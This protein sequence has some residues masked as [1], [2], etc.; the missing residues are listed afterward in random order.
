MRWLP[1]NRMIADGLTKDRQEPADLL[2]SCVRAGIYQIS[3]EESVLARQAA[4]R[5]ER[6]RLNQIKTVEV[7]REFR[8]SRTM[9]PRTVSHSFWVIHGNM[10]LD[11]VSILICEWKFENG[12][13]C[14]PDS[15]R[16]CLPCI[17]LLKGVVL[18]F[19]RL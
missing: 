15:V 5:E 2:R 12:H 8:L 16:F 11:Y 18:N 17:L 14:M 3:P 19:A 4:E 9:F 13:S 7:S 10:S 6:T 1:T